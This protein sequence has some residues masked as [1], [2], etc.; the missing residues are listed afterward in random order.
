MLYCLGPERKTRAPEATPYGACVDHCGRDNFNIRISVSLG[1]AARTHPS[2]Q[3][4]R[5]RVMGME[6]DDDGLLGSCANSGTGNGIES[7]SS[8][9]AGHGDKLSTV[10]SHREREE[11]GKFYY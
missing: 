7:G 5:A 9:E 10:T 4:E 8:R 3:G 2:R 1:G 11:E 6:E